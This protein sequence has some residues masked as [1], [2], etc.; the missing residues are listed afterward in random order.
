L[1]HRHGH[2]DDDHLV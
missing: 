1:L 2:L